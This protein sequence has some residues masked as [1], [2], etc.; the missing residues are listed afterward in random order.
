MNIQY[1]IGKWFRYIEIAYSIVVNAYFGPRRT[2]R[3]HTT[4]N[5]GP[6]NLGLKLI[7]ID[8]HIILQKK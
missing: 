5:Y 4:P 3:P 1:G 2:N 6:E 8:R 7:I